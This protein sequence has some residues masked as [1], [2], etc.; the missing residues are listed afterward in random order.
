MQLTGS[1]GSWEASVVDMV[2]FLSALDGTRTKPFLSERSFE[3]MVAPVPPPVPL[4]E[5]G[6]TFGLG[7]DTVQKVDG[8]VHF[9]KGGGV[10]GVHTYI[11]HLPNNVDIAY[12]FNGSGLNQKP[13]VAAGA[14]NAIHRAIKRVQHWPDINLFDQYK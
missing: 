1:L 10:T 7:W 3:A 12:F 2:K 11:E 5:N 6:A 13:K 9:A 8:G 14:S 4:R